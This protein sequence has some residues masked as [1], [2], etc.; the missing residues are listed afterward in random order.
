M[1]FKCVVF[2][3]DG[4]LVD[5]LEDIAL[6]M[7]T[8]LCERGF[9][10]LPGEDYAGIV[11]NGI[12]HLAYLALPGENRDEKLAREL[13]ERAARLYAEKPVV[14]S[15]IYPGILELIFGLR[16]LRIKTA[17]LTNKPD[18]VARMV[19]DRLFPA[20]TFEAVQGETPGVPRKPDPASTWELLMRLDVTPRETVFAGDS[21]VDLET[22][23]AAECSPLLVS[24]GFRSREALEKASAPRIIDRPGELLD[25]VRETRI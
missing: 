18:P 1:R 22:A 5:T 9:P 12:R 16:N 19:I 14:H 7:N 25:L 24:W 8:A 21:E 2:D 17:V 11:G 23:L 6:A 20:G 15:K 13:A 10:A 4:T 3:L